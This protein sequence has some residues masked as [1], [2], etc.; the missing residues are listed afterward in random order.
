LDD[1]AKLVLAG[2]GGCGGWDIALDVEERQI[3]RKCPGFQ[4]TRRDR[5]PTGMAK[6]V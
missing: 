6:I 4:A 5:L 2:R 3:K 1:E